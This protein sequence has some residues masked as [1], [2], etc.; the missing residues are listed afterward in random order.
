MQLKNTKVSH[1][2]I[3]ERD[4]KFIRFIW[5]YYAAKLSHVLAHV[6]GGIGV[7]AI[8]LTLWKDCRAKDS[9]V[10]I[11]SFGREEFHRHKHCVRTASMIRISLPEFV[12]VH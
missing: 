3:K 1:L 4:W 6:R 8:E 9:T 11:V 10:L 5:R 2:R 12:F 7:S